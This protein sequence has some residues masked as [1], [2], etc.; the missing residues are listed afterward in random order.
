MK[1][2]LVLTNM[3]L[4]SIAV[5]RRASPDDLSHSHIHHGTQSLARASALVS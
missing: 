4:P 5:H 1:G 3:E 2:K